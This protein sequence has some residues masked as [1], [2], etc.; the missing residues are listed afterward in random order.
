[1]TASHVVLDPQDSGY[2]RVT[3]KNGKIDTVEGVALGVLIPLNPAMLPGGFEFHPFQDAW[4][5]G[6]WKKSPLIREADQL[7]SL[8]DIAVC[9][10]PERADG[11]AYQP[12]NLSL[13]PFVRGE[14]ACAIGYA[15]ME[16]I[17]IQY[18]NGQPR[19]DKF[20]WELYVSTGEVSEVFPLNHLEPAVP[21]HGPCFEFRA[22]IPGKM[23]GSPIFGARGAVIRGVVSRSYSGEKHA[24]L[25]DRGRQ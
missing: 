14:T 15:L 11:S 6:E 3:A 9:K 23:S 21:T 12:L 2:G 16:D 24:Y 7:A 17:P 5:W 10:L 22:R 8:I 19:I 25:H 1:M 4:Y 13:T 20:P 18:V